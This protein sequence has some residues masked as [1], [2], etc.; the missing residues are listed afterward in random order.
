MYDNSTSFLEWIASD[1][2]RVVLPESDFQR[3]P[4]QWGLRNIAASSEKRKNK[5]LFV[6]FVEDDFSDIS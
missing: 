1:V 4:G 3:T 5:K 6:R 2:F